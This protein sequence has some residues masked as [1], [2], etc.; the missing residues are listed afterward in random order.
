MTQ[1]LHI[2]LQPDYQTGRAQEF[3]GVG[4]MSVGHL[5]HV[6]RVG[7]GRAQRGDPFLGRVENDSQ[8][9]LGLLASEKETLAHSPQSLCAR[10]RADQVAAVEELRLLSNAVRAVRGLEPLG[11]QRDLEPATIRRRRVNLVT[12]FGELQSEAV[13]AC[14]RDRDLLVETGALVG[15]TRT[16]HRLQAL[17]E[18][19]QNLRALTTQKV[20]GVRA[21]G[22]Q[23]TR[24]LETIPNLLDNLPNSLLTGAVGVKAQP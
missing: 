1:R 3:R 12:D 13:N 22:K 7:L 20:V 2:V 18:L 16:C 5:G 6:C 11:A 4:S 8:M 9:L 10:T 21:R 17:D 19:A 23:H 24:E 15:A 14:L